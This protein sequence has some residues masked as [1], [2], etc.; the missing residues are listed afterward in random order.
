MFVTS[1]GFRAPVTESIHA[2]D[3]EYYVQ[4]KV[5]VGIRCTRYD[6]VSS[7]VWI[8]SIPVLYL[9]RPHWMDETAKFSMTSLT[10]PPY[11]HIENVPVG[12]GA[13]LMFSRQKEL[14]TVHRTSGSLRDFL[15]SL[16]ATTENTYNKNPG[17]RF[18]FLEEEVGYVGYH[19]N[20]L[21]E[22][23]KIVSW[24]HAQISKTLLPKW[25]FKN[26]PKSGGFMCCP[27]GSN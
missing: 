14:L 16:T 15:E 25:K 10:L 24:T 8:P 26:V 9:P 2:E 13:L 3:F 27:T 6:G 18:A 23:G 20:Y 11:Q 22:N 7:K 5:P 19:Q 12:G 21:D 1:L 4:T 17:Y